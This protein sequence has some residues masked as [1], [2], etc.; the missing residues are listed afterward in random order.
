LQRRFAALCLIDVVKAVT[1]SLHR[2]YFSR[3]RGKRCSCRAYLWSED[4]LMKPLVTIVLLLALVV[5]VALGGYGVAWLLLIKA[6]N[7]LT[8]R[9][10]ALQPGMHVLDVG[11]GSGRFTIP[12]AQQVG[13]KGSVLGIDIDARKIQRAEQ[14]LQEASLANVRFERA[15]AGEGKLP[16]DQFDRALLFAVLGEMSDREAAL[17][18]IFQALKSGGILSIT[19]GFLDPH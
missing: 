4:Q 15:G 18:E 5:I 19:E 9:Q 6:G 3:K 16:H 13:S 7:R 10:L 2:T 12:M 8:K 1:R 14:H 17:A 11:C